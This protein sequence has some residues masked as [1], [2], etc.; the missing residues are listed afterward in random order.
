MITNSHALPCSVLFTISSCVPWRAWNH[1]SEQ[2]KTTSRK[3]E[4]LHTA[5]CTASVSHVPSLSP[6]NW[7]QTKS[8]FLLIPLLQYLSFPDFPSVEG[9]TILLILSAKPL[10]SKSLHV[11]ALPLLRFHMPFITTS[12]GLN[13]C[14]DT[15]V[16]LLQCFYPLTYVPYYFSFCLF[17]EDPGTE[18][19]HLLQSITIW[20]SFSETN[21]FSVSPKKFISSTF[22]PHNEKEKNSYE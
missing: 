6:S 11:V 2:I 20:S 22:V 4:E 19:Q 21:K 1:L 16:L 7:K 17:R 13:L 10:L 8:C 5:L 12:Y 9:T 3:H 14:E 15:P 18:L